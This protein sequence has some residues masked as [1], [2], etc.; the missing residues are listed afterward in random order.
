MSFFWKD[1][2]R[3]SRDA[4]ERCHGRGL[5][6]PRLIDFLTRFAR[7]YKPIDYA[8]SK[9]EQYSFPPP[10]SILGAMLSNTTARVLY[11]LPFAGYFILYSDF[12]E[13]HFE[14]SIRHSR[15]GFLTFT[16]RINMI[17]YGSVILLV[18]FGL[19]RFFSPPLLRGKRDLQ[20]FVSDIVVARDRS[21]V[22][23]A[24]HEAREFLQAYLD[25]EPT[26]LSK[27]DKGN[28]EGLL[29]NCMKRDKLGDNAGEYES[30]I[31]Q[32]LIFYFNWQNFR[33]PAFRTFV[34]CCTLIGYVLLGLPALDLF[35]RVSH[36]T[37]CHLWS[38][39]V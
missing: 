8:N 33:F 24:N 26:D 1:H 29:T 15:W 18:A 32:I 13:R 27:D 7:Q 37:I 25:K 36:T 9:H 22:R 19:Y 10:W 3:V 4:P 23:L 34:F 6:T 20:H 12:F 16:S 14:Y 21:T 38:D 2:R 17:Y 39:C 31:P 5:V 30:L 28:L 11:V 35:I